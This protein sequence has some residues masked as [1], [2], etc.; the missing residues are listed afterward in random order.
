MPE[1]AV[2]APPSTEFQLTPQDVETCRDTCAAIQRELSKVIV[3]QSKVIEEI[4]I[5]IFT[6]SRPAWDDSSRTLMCY[7]T[8][9]GG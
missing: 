6:R 4:L 5:A 3:G 1:A 8:V 2:P 9:P 7:E